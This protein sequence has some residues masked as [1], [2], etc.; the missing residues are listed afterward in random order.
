MNQLTMRTA[1]VLYGPRIW[2][3][4]LSPPCL[5]RFGPL[6]NDLRF[7]FRDSVSLKD[8]V[9]IRPWRTNVMCRGLIALEALSETQSQ[10]FLNTSEGGVRFE[11]AW[12][13]VDVDAWKCNSWFV[14]CYDGFDATIDSADA[15]CRY[16]KNAK[17]KTWMPIARGGKNIFYGYLTDSWRVQAMWDA[18]LRRIS[19]KTP[20]IFSCDL[21]HISARK[22][23]E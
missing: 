16:M 11:Y 12:R 3:H 19:L 22:R 20:G 1:A 15:I 18:P 14:P 17:V 23:K 5:V 6:K 9:F 8:D 21:I 13:F 7:R 10:C 4:V 2:R